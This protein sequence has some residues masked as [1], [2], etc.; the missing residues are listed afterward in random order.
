ML[1]NWKLK[2][3]V[4]DDA[5]EYLWPYVTVSNTQN[6]SISGPN[7]LIWNYFYLAVNGFW[8]YHDG[9]ELGPNFL[10]KIITTFPTEDSLASPNMF[11]FSPV[12]LL[13]T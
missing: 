7:A 1:P 13:N 9:K 6:H 10:L 3:C 5:G 4:W 11:Y 2:W 8:Q 12:G